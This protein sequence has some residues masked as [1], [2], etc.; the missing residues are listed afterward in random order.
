MESGNQIRVTCLMVYTCYILVKFIIMEEVDE[1][2]N[3]FSNL[4]YN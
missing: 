3:E 4:A 2:F 1:S